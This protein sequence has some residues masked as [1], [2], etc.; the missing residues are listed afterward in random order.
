MLIFSVELLDLQKPSLITVPSG[1]GLYTIVGVVFVLVL[2]GY[3]LYR[4][5]SSEGAEGRTK[6]GGVNKK[7]GKRR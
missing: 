2:I 4:R 6:K 3:E 7:K 1:S 5:A